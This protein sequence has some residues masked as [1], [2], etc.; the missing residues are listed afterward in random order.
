[1]NTNVF[2]TLKRAML[3]RQY[4]AISSSV[5]PS[6]PSLSSM[7]T[8]GVSPHC[9]ETISTPTPHEHRPWRCDCQSGCAQQNIL[10]E[11][12]PAVVYASPQSHT[13]LPRPRKARAQLTKKHTRQLHHLIAGTS[14]GSSHRHGRMRRDHLLHLDRGDI[15]SPG[16][17]DVLGTVLEL[18][19]PSGT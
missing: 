3:L 2:G 9:S 8:H 1:M 6:T 15:F 11:V 18:D 10:R 13:R 16:N 4:S 19:V 14:N 7:K 17:D 12:A 5:T